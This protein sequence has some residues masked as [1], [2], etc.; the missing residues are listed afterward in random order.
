MTRARD[1]LFVTLIL[2][3]APAVQVFGQ[4]K[5]PTFVDATKDA[6]VAFTHTFAYR[7]LR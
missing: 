1:T 6:R 2:T 7:Y 3:L 4:Q 5:S